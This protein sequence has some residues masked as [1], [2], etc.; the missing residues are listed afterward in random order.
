MNLYIFKEIPFSRTSPI[1][2]CILSDSA[3][4]ALTSTFDE[5]RHSPVPIKRA[6]QNTTIAR[7]CFETHAIS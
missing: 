2:F 5:A 6:K 3:N 1:N 7:L 4:D